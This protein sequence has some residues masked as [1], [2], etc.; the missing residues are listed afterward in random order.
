[1]RERG[2]LERELCVHDLLNMKHDDRFITLSETDTVQAAFKMMKDYDISQLP[3][4]REGEMVGSITET[5]VLSYLLENPMN[6]AEQTVAAIMGA[7]FPLVEEDLPFSQL[8]K[9]V[10]RT[11]PAVI[12]KDKAGTLHILTQYDIIRAV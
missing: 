9:Y 4:M 8:S 1:M 7:P 3:V 10:D 2:F 11:I 12:A 5:A 6:H